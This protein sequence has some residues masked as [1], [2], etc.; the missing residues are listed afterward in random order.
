MTSYLS[1]I[2]QWPIGIVHSLFRAVYDMRTL[3][4]FFVFPLPNCASFYAFTNSLTI[5]P[6]I[7]YFI[8]L[9]I[10]TKWMNDSL[11]G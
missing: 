3:R 9:L 6:L 11:I 2:R 10:P 4:Q 8:V 1:T 7:D 5:A